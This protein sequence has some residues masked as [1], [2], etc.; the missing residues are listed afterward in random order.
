MPTGKSS[1]RLFKVFGIQ[2]YLHWSW[3]LVAIYEI[4]LREG[5]YSSV[6]WN[7]LEYVT[8]FLIVL[9]HEFG[10]AFA[11]RSVGGRA[12]QIVL[13]PLGGVAYVAPPRRPGAQ[14]WSIV[15]GPLVNVALFPILSALWWYA[16][17]ADWVETMPNLF[18]YV[19]SI[20]EINL[21]LLIFNMLPIYPLDGGK[22]LRSLLWFVLGPYRSLMAA[23]VIGFVGAAGFA[24]F[25]I[26]AQSVWIG[27]ISVFVFYQCFQSFKQARELS[28]IANAPRREGFACPSCKAPPPVGEFWICGKC[29]KKF[30]TFM[31]QATCPHCGMQF[32]RTVCLDCG[33][34]SPISEW[35]PGTFAKV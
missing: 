5:R 9:L 1:F 35:S 10:H 8:L 11:C 15:A 17:S 12:D 6:N 30:D 22:I 24:V 28:R 19:F 23:A 31:S 20:W 34:P 33:M 26:L 32:A 2:V 29:R 13:W 27:V 18:V 21:V 7:V 25:A 16:K 4:Q 3:F 14:L